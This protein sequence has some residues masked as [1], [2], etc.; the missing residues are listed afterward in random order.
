MDPPQAHTNNC[1]N[2]GSIQI[3]APP[4]PPTT[5]TAAMVEKSTKF[6]QLTLLALS[7]WCKLFPEDPT[8][9]FW[10]QLEENKKAVDNRR[11]LIMRAVVCASQ[12]LTVK[13]GTFYLS[14][15]MAKDIIGLSM[16]PRGQIPVWETIQQGLSILNQL[17]AT[18][19]WI[20]VTQWHKRRGKHEAYPYVREGR[21]TREERPTPTSDNIRYATEECHHI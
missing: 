6:S 16:A 7:G 8:P 10:K 1:L 3:Q 11:C 21:E 19:A 9:Y 14:D 15:Q 13:I 2:C 20:Q 12:A 18:S 17:P 5:S 4:P